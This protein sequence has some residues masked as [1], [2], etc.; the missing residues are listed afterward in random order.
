MNKRGKKLLSATKLC[1]FLLCAVLTAAPASALAGEILITFESISGVTAMNS[2]FDG[3]SVV[4]AGARLST[5]L[6]MSS[7]VSFSSTAGYVAV[8]RLGS[9]HA[10]SGVNGIGGVNA[11]GVIKYNQP[12]N[13]TFSMPGSPSTPAVTDFVSIRGDNFWVANATATMQ[14]FDVNGVLIG[15]V[16][17]AENFGLTLSL[18]APNIHSVRLTQM[19]S[20]IAYDD[21]QFS[22]LSPATSERPT[23]NAGPDQPTRPGQ[24]VTLDGS[25]S[26]DD[27]TATESL[28]FAW[29]LIGR[30]DGSAA[31]LANADSARPS[32]VA[33]LPGEYVASLTV[34]DADG[35]A[36]DPDTVVVSSLN[37]APV[38]EAGA[39]RAA[40]VGDTIALDGSASHDPDTDAL[41]LSW[42][43]T[44]PEGSAAALSGELTAYPTFTPDV[45]GTYTATLT[46]SDPF[47][48][49]S[50]DSVV[51]SAIT[52]E[53]FVA[54][55][56]A[57][58]LNL[59]GALTL[60]QVTTRGNR[61]ALQNYL[62]QALAALRAGDTDEARSKLMQA[63]ER[64]DGCVLRG[65]PDGNGSGRDWV[66]DCAAQAALYEKLNAALSALT[67]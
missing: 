45:A 53:E 23:A 48:G 19:R 42:T 15:S 25:G 43:L 37:A 6:Q 61:Q 35:Q 21:L 57:D 31:A 62:A 54:R 39:D 58:A 28:G 52:A 18:S 60:E 7:G 59:L 26:S 50:A 65:G 49:M 66:T 9:G 2:F 33:D 4:P 38:A 14:G 29:T 40:F 47:G 16:T 56:I 1:S 32:F 10:T 46:V 24:T 27:N 55:Q 41:S 20:D 30:P 17:A 34:T 44:A 64:T 22:P 5:Q 3:S 13:I 51:V 67:P 36:S 8:V 63:A 11:S 12:V